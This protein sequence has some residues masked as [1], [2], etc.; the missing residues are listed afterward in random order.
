MGQPD[1]VRNVPGH[2][3][4]A[5]NMDQVKFYKNTVG[6]D[7]HPQIYLVDKQYLEAYLNCR[8]KST[9]TI[10]Q[11]LETLL[12]A[13]GVKHIPQDYCKFLKTAA[14]AVIICGAKEKQKLLET[15]HPQKQQSFLQRQKR[16]I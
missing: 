14:I 13:P 7:T 16:K 11:K 15:S 3:V 8:P 2:D 6:G 12:R 10:K 4:P 5:Q 1:N 9:C